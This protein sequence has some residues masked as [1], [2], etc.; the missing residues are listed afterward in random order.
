MQLESHGL[1]II[2][3]LYTLSAKNFEMEVDTARGD[4]YLLAY[5]PYF[6][7]IKVGLCDR[8]AVCLCAPPINF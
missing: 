4:S 1:P 7:K 5:F 6:E 2:H 3:A 8:H